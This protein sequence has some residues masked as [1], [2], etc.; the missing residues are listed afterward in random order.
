MLT[1]FGRLVKPNR[2]YWLELAVTAP[3]RQGDVLLFHSNLFH[4]AGC[5]QTTATKFS[6]VFTYRAADNPPLPGSRSA[7]LEEIEI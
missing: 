4:A 6:M 7:S 5:N 2:P 1:K 3:L